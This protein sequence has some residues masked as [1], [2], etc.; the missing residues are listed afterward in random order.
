MASYNLEEGAQ[1]WYLMVQANEGTP[2]WRR[3]TELLHLRYGLP[4]R[5]APLA[6]LAECRRIGTVAEYQDRFQAL[7]PHAGPLQ[8]A[9]RVQLFVGGLQPPLS[10]DVRI[11]NPQTMA[12]AMSLAR[13]F[14]LREQFVAPVTRAPGRRLLPAPAARLALPTPPGA[15]PTEPGTITV[16]GRTIKRLL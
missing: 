5:S 11:Q 3:F 13:Q 10:I 6:E 12:A 8:E 2:S 4:L 1:M 7:L 15:K 14:E 9:Q 16:E